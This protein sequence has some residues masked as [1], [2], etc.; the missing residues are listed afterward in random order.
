MNR[1]KYI[2]VAIGAVAALATSAMVFNSFA[3]AAP[4]TEVAIPTTAAEHAAEATRY[5]QE[6]LELDQKAQ[7]HAKMARGYQARYSG[8]SKQGTMLLS[9]VEHC[10][11]LAK[12]YAEAA[13]EARATAKSHRDMAKTA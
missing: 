1:F 2:L 5:D 7:R 13:V 8:G 4:A 9:L 10:K 6:A 12:I 3:S 11:R